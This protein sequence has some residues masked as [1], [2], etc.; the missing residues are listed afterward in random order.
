MEIFDFINYDEME[1]LINKA[2]IIITHGG[3]GSII[4]PC[5]KGK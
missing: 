5:K 3:T 1:E 2:D 4:I